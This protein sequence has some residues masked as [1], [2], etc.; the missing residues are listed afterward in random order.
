MNEKNFSQRQRPVP[1]Q[2]YKHFKGNIYQI[3]CIAVDSEDGKECVVY[4][5]LYGD[6]KYYVRPLDMFMSEVDH[7]KYPDVTQKYRFELISA[8][9]TPVPASPAVSEVRTAASAD[10]SVRSTPIPAGNLSASA[11]G[12]SS[13]DSPFSLDPDLEAF[14]DADT[15]D[16]RLEILSR[17]HVRIDDDM[18]DFMSASIDIEIPA[19]RTSDR[20]EKLKDALMLRR[21]FE[22]GR[23]R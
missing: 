1:Q 6:Y 19:G 5:A 13:E 4:Q 2:I 22:S 14:L 12:A 17:M 3:N 23:L 10:A 21:K 15:C 8:A 18:I 16:Q 20:Y 7:E 11:V 9:D